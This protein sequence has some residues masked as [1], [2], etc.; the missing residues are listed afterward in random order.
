MIKVLHRKKYGLDWPANGGTSHVAFRSQDAAPDGAQ[1]N[2]S[3][4]QK[5][6]D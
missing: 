3:L 6:L 5:L 1:K 2:P 4:S